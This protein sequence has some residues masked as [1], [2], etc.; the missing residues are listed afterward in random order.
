MQD[1]QDR[2]KRSKFILLYPNK[3]PQQQQICVVF[4][5]GCIQ[6]HSELSIL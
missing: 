3:H 5:I 2:A 6:A 1:T 4:S